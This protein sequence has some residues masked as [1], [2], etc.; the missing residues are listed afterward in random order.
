MVDHKE[1]MPFL[2]A[3]PFS[4]P[5]HS[6]S[7]P[8]PITRIPALHAIGASPAIAFAKKDL[9]ID[10]ETRESQRLSCA[11]FVKLSQRSLWCTITFERV[12]AA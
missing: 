7:P 4:N 8:R 11:N 10:I 9:R 6:S 12:E 1:N 5:T 2:R 3:K